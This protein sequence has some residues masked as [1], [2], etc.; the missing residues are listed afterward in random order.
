MEPVLM[1]EMYLQQLHLKASSLVGKC[2]GMYFI[3]MLTA[4][5]F[6]PEGTFFGRSVHCCL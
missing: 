6:T 4:E 1:S 3:C 5:C 2:E